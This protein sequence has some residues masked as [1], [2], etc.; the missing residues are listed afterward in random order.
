[1]PL[2]PDRRYDGIVIDAGLTQSDEKGTPAIWWKIKTDAGTIDNVEWVSQNTSKRI[3]DTM[4]K[5]FGTTPE[6]LADMGYFEEL[7]IRLRGAE[8]SI[9]TEAEERRDHT[10]ETKVKWMNPRGIPKKAPTPATKSKVAAL[11]GWKAVTPLPGRSSAPDDE[12]PPFAPFSDDVP[13]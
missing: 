1:M 3:A 4:S 5:C 9:T 13:F 2:E 10:F 6:Q 7:G 11:F 8:V 12:P